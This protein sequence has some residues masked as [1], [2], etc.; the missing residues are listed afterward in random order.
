[1]REKYPHALEFL[2]RFEKQLRARRGL[3][4]LLAEGSTAPYWS[5]FGVGDYTLARHKVV[6]KDIATD[7]AAAVVP[8]G[9]PCPLPGHTVMLVACASDDEAH[10]V[11]GLLNS[12][13]VRAFVGAYVA[14]HISTHTTKMIHVPRCE[15]GKPAHAAVAQ[16]SRAAHAAVKAGKEPDQG[17]VDGAAGKVWGL[18]KKEVGELGEFLDQLLKRDLA[19]E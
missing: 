4:S 14:T 12:I 17:S 10:Y 9:D 3:R 5:M 15:M 19:D 7:F 16:A 8:S 2:N 13:P 11:C 1:M 6:W 18:T